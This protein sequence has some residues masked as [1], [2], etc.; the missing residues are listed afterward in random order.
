VLAASLTTDLLRHQLSGIERFSSGQRLFH[1]E[2]Y[3]KRHESFANDDDDYDDELT[4]TVAVIC[5]RHDIN[6]TQR[7]RVATSPVGIIPVVDI[8]LLSF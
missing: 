1:I 2:S 8:P 6:T 4:T 3:M 5:L 7:Y